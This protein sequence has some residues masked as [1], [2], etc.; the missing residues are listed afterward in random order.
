MRARILA[1]A[2]LMLGLGTASAQ[3]EFKQYASSEGRYKILFPGPVK[4]ES[5]DVNMDKIKLK[6]T[7]DSVELRAGTTFMVSYVD[8]SEEVAK[9]PSGPRFDKVRDANKG[10][11]GKVR[12]EKDLTIGVEKYT[13][14][15]RAH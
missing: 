4:T 15:R 7:I 13:A 6:V 11:A 2:V 9:S 3:V 8:A 10:E 5:F 12:E 1:T 14:P